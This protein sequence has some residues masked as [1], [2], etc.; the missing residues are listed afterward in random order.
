MIEE[1]VLRVHPVLRRIPIDKLRT[2]LSNDARVF[3]FTSSEYGEFS[4]MAEG[5]PLTIDGYVWPSAES[6]YQACRF[7][8]DP[9]LQGKIIIQSS[10]R[11]AKKISRENTEKTRDDW[12]LIRTKV[13]RWVLHIK[14]MQY[15]KDFLFSLSQT[16]DS[17]L[18]EESRK[19][20]YWGA[21]R[22]D[23]YLVGMNVLGRLLMELRRDAVS[24]ELDLMK[25]H[26]PAVRNFKLLEKVVGPVAPAVGIS[27]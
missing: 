14:A 20:A 4:N 21:V 10:A 16:G 26:P 5:F 19:D 8:D 22:I 9:E 1:Q 23:E 13:M 18:V 25:V 17:S 12:F 2:Y 15:K 7:P 24:G 11:L 6:L 27:R 3:F